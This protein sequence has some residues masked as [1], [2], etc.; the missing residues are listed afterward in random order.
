ML[1]SYHTRG[2]GGI[3]PLMYAIDENKEACVKAL[4]DGGADPNLENT[5]G[6]GIE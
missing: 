6:R 4:I 1:P 3:T 2:Q 5:V